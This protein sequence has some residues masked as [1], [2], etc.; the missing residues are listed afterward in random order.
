M[1]IPADLEH[2]LPQDQVDV[3]RLADAE[4]YPKVHL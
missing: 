3:A 1:G 4:A 2:S